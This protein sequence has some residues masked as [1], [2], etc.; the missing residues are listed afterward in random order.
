MLDGQSQ[1]LTTA[2]QRLALTRFA[3]FTIDLSGL[4]GRSADRRLSVRE[5][6]TATLL[7]ADEAALAATGETR[8]VLL[9]EAHSRIA[10]PLLAVAAP[11]VGFAA[12]MLGGFSRFGMVR[13]IGVAVGL[14]IVLQ[15]VST[16]GS[17]LAIRDEAAWPLVYLAPVVGIG[18]AAALLWYAQRP[19]SIRPAQVPA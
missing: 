2:D 1:A 5:L 16:F 12:L 14:L 7:S 4:L 13:Q 17:G 19:R 18:L 9:E 6:S 3:T 8:A 11:L 15:S 10:S